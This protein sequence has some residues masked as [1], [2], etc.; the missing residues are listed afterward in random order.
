[1]NIFIEIIIKT[2]LET[3]YLT[4]TVILIGF[5]L[6]VLRN[7][8]L[9]N[10]QRSF[11]S[12]ALMITGFIGVPI[13]ELS[14]AILAVFFRHRI[15]SIKLLQKPD[16]N[17]VMGYVNHS[18]SKNS[19]YQQIGNFFIGIAPIFGGVF[20]IVALMHFVIPKSYNK[21]IGILE[22]G[23]K[24]TTLN[25]SIV[26]GIINSYIGLFK[27][28]FSLENF[29]NP[30]FYIF[31][32]ISI[33]ISSHISLSSADIKGASRGLTIIFAI[34]LI[35]NIFGLSKYISEINII[36][37]NILLTGVL[38]VAVILSIITYVISLFAR[39]IKI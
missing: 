32:F 10:F 35:L 34:L 1:M 22:S 15:N 20:S 19:I 4:G 30:Y 28:I 5:L 27:N 21:L 23:L 3:F 6:G 9:R 13:H 33:C 18:Y 37:Y 2:I 14:H 11:G 39:S 38:L 26:E 12:K 24:V 7:S 25:K 8:T 17:G 36:R 16:V 29:K 31:L